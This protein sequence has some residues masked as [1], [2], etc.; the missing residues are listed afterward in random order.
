L[1]LGAGLGFRVAETAFLAAGAAVLFLTAGDL[2]DARV[3][4]TGFVVTEAAFGVLD[5]A[6]VPVLTKDLAGFLAGAAALA[7]TD[8]LAGTT[9]AF[10]LGAVTFAVTFAA[11]FAVTFAGTFLF[12]VFT[13]C[14]LAVLKGR[15]KPVA[16]VQQ[17]IGIPVH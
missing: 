16:A 4:E 5:G 13:S 3:V 10:T 9:L 6:A 15:S 8:F 7:G 14:L 11:A 12:K 17:T 1:A 2:L